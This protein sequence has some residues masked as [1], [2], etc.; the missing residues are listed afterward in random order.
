LLPGGNST[1]KSLVLSSV[2]INN[3][4]VEIIADGLGRNNSVKCFSYRLG[5]YEKAVGYLLE[6]LQHVQL[7]S[8]EKVEF[9]SSYALSG[10]CFLLISGAV[11]QMPMLTSLKVKRLILSVLDWEHLFSALFRPSSAR[12]E[13]DVTFERHHDS[14]Q[15]STKVIRM[16]CRKQ[17]TQDIESLL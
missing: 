1:L 14:R 17:V 6:S 8:L 13:L 11:E 5:L 16:F 12:R 2:Q 10:S 4:N 15:H 7:Y 3:A 9:V